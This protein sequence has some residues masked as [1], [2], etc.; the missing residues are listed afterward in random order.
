MWSAQLSWDPVFHD[1]VNFVLVHFDTSGLHHLEKTNSEEFGIHPEFVILDSLRYVSEDAI[2]CVLKSSFDIFLCLS[3]HPFRKACGLGTDNSL[4]KVA[5]REQGGTNSLVHTI[6]WVI[7]QQQFKGSKHTKRPNRVLD[8]SS[9]DSDQVNGSNNI[10][11]HVLVQSVDRVAVLYR[12]SGKGFSYGSDFGVDVFVGSEFACEIGISF[13]WLVSNLHTSIEGE[14]M[15]CSVKKNSGE[16][17]EQ[18]MLSKTEHTIEP[19]SNRSSNTRFNW[20]TIG[21]ELVLQFHELP[22]G[23][24]INLL[25]CQCWE[26]R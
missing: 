20:R 16:N 2:V 14:F 6:F 7:L 4:I 21:K 25:D 18:I 5:W 1:R 12:E 11:D 23:S 13:S 9:V 19:N 15:I 22:Q 26:G 3:F 17:T 10:I 24:S 8:E